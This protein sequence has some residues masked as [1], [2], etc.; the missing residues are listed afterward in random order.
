MGLKNKEIKDTTSSKGRDCGKME[1][2]DQHT[3]YKIL[4]E[5]LKMREIHIF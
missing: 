5:L 2:Y 1:K 3:M 4:R